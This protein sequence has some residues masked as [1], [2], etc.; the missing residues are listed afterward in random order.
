MW[1]DSEKDEKR[2]SSEINNH[3]REKKKKEDYLQG[4]HFS[5]QYCQIHFFQWLSSKQPK[6]K[7]L[8]TLKKNPN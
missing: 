2:M 4:S 8:S 1:G 5:D 7:Y 3:L 6:L